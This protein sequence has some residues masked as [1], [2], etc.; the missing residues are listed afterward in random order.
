MTKHP[1]PETGRTPDEAAPAVDALLSDDQ[2]RWLRQAVVAMTVVLVAGVAV[3]IGRV[4]YLARASGTQAASSATIAALEPILLPD[5]RLSLPA[6]A[7][8][9][10]ISLTGIRVAVLYEAAEGAGDMIAVLDL[11]TGK[12]ISRVTVERGKPN[13]G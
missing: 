2:I 4:I 12:V 6:G 3:L 7:R 5:V 10:Q 13:G 11:T 9:K 8:I 1:L